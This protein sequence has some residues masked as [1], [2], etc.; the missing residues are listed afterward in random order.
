LSE[1]LGTLLGERVI[2][3]VPDWVAFNFSTSIIIICSIIVKIPGLN[4]L[5]IYA[6]FLIQVLFVGISFNIAFLMQ[7]LK[8]ENPALKAIS[9]ELNMSIGNSFTFLCPLVAKAPEPVPT[10]MFIF[11]GVSSMVLLT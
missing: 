4:Q 1:S 2:Q 5:F 10:L 3:L 7:E 11:L 8:T 9:L 6:V